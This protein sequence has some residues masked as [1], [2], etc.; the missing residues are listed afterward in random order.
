MPVNGEMLSMLR[1]LMK[2]S[3]MTWEEAQTWTPNSYPDLSPLIGY[4]PLLQGRY[5]AM[6]DIISLSDRRQ[7]V[8]AGTWE[9][10]PDQLLDNPAAASGVV[11]DAAVQAA[12]AAVYNDSGS[13]R[14]VVR[15][16]MAA[17]LLRS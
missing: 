11:G 10:F 6:V 7:P 8:D 1:W 14:S 16:R 13:W 5:V 12:L 3:E 4:R 15:A 9:Q 17:W 2:I